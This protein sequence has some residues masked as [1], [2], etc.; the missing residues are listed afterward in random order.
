MTPIGAS[1]TVRSFFGNHLGISR[2]FPCGRV[3]K[4]DSCRNVAIGPS[5][6]GPAGPQRRA[7]GDDVVDQDHRRARRRQ[8]PG[9][10][11]EAPRQVRR[12]RRG[13]QPDGVARPPA[14]PERGRD[15]S[16][17]SPRARCRHNR[18]TWSPPRARAADG[19]DGAGTSHTSAEPAIWPSGGMSREAAGRR[20]RAA[21]VPCTRERRCAAARGTARCRDRWAHRAAPATAAGRAAPHSRRTSPS[22]ARRSRRRSLAGAGRAAR[23]AGSPGTAWGRRGETKRSSCGHPAGPGRRTCPASRR[24][25]S[26]PHV[27]AVSQA[28]RHSTGRRTR[29]SR[30]RGAPRPG[31]RPPPGARTP[32]RRRRSPTPRT[33][34]SPA[35]AVRRGGDRAQRRG[36]V[37]A[38]QQVPGQ[39]VHRHLG[40]RAVGCGGSP[41]RSSRPP[42]SRRRRPRPG[43]P[44]A[45]SGRCGP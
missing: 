37:A 20:G 12:P 7:G 39:P 28:R 19:R 30:D 34:R 1:A 4:N 31:R 17:G 24:G 32:G 35:R 42:A 23:R 33:G 29:V 14:Q 41:P 44:A 45:A 11:P 16:P 10:H 25:P 40:D 3:G 8:G 21:R 43:P 6:G 13:V 2:C 27:G 9:V 5:E 36:E 38:G 22:P 15:R 26:C 18:S